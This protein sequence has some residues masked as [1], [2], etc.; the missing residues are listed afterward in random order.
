MKNTLT[1]TRHKLNDQTAFQNTPPPPPLSQKGCS[2]R[3][4][5][6]QDLEGNFNPPR[7]AEWEANL[8]KKLMQT[9]VVIVS[10]SII[11]TSTVNL[12]GI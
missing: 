11:N 7:N 10:G 8:I 6:L 5:V 2:D 9:S 1:L 12:N 4:S 3:A